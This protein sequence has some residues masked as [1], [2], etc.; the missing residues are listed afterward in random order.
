[1]F[2]LL[3][4]NYGGNGSSTFGLPDLRSRVPVHFGQGSGLSN[5]ALGEST[6]V[7]SRSLTIAQM[8]AHTHTVNATA[9][10]ASNGSPKSKYLAAS[11]TPLYLQTPTALETMS[12]SML[13]IAGGGQAFGVIQ[14]LLAINFC[15]A[16]TGVYPSRN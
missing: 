4:T 16:L 6:G 9:E 10:S 2:S 12:P 3:G 5:Y 7:E 8:P 15:I 1:L 14:P 11:S 13:N